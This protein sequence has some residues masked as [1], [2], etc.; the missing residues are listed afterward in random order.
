MDIICPNCDALHGMAK[1]LEDSPRRRPF[2][3][4]ML[5]Q[6]QSFVA[7]PFKAISFFAS[8]F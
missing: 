3:S 8:I 2:F 1:R 5:S 7:T 4:Y 6:G